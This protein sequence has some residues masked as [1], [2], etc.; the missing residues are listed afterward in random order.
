MAKYD[1]MIWGGMVIDPANNRHSRLDV[2][3]AG[4]KVAA[5][6]FTIHRRTPFPSTIEMSST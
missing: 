2:A 1:L 3:V 4:R 6:F 5:V